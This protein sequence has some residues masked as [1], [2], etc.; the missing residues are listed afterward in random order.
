[1]TNPA[2]E[3]ATFAPMTFHRLPLALLAAAALTTPLRA[4]ATDPDADLRELLRDALYTEEVTRDPEAAAKQYEALLSK[5]DAQR[6]FAASALFRLAEVRRK[7][8]RKDEAIA[9][10]QRLLR[11]FPAAEAEA[12][13]AREN[14]AAMG[15]KPAEI[16]GPAEEREMS[17]VEW[18]LRN[19]QRDIEQLKELVESSPDVLV[20]KLQLAVRDENPL[21]VDF[22]LSKG[23]DPATPGLLASA[24][25]SG[26]L[27]ICKMLIEKGKPSKEEAGNALAEAVRTGRMAILSY[28]LDQGLDPDSHVSHGFGRRITLLGIAV[29]TGNSE[30]AKEFLDR[31][32]DIDTM[33]PA[34][35][36][37]GRRESAG[38]ALHF[39]VRQKNGLAMVR[40]LLER[41]AKPDVPT[42]VG[43][44]T[45]LHLAVFEDG[46]QSEMIV[47][48]LLAR[49]ADPNRSGTAELPKRMVAGPILVTP[50]EAALEL[51]AT[52]KI[53]S[54]LG[55]GADL[56]A[57]DRRGWPPLRSVIE[58]Q[59]PELVREFLKAGADPNGRDADGVPMLLAAVT[60][61][62][63]SE[64]VGRSPDEHLVARSQHREMVQVLLDASADPSAGHQQR[65]PVR[66]A[67]GQKNLWPIAELLL[68]RGAKPDEDWKK[69]LFDGAD[70]ATRVRLIRRF[71][72]PEMAA[73][74][75]ITCF[76]GGQ[77]AVGFKELLSRKGDESPPPLHRLL[78]DLLEKQMQPQN[79]MVHDTRGNN[80]NY[81]ER[82]NEI[83]I[84]RH[85]PD[86]KASELRVDLLSN[87]P[88]PDLQWG[89][90]LEF[91]I[92]RP[93]ANQPAP[94]PMW[95]F[96]KR[97]AF[98]VTVEIEGRTRRVELRGD[99]LM[100]DP[101]SDQ[102]PWVGAGRLMSLLW[103]PVGLAASTQATEIVIERKGWPV[104]RL[105]IG[106]T[107]TDNLA[108]E[109]EDIVR[110]VVEKAD[111]AGGK[112]A[113]KEWWIEP[114][115]RL[116]RVTL[117]TPG[118]PYTRH[119]GTTRAADVR[120]PAASLPTL[121]QALAET[122][123]PAEFGGVPRDPA[124]VPAWL[125]EH[126]ADFPLTILPHPDFSKIRLRRLTDAG[127]EEVRDIDLTATIADA[128]DATTAVEARQADLILQ[129]GDIIELP[130][131]PDQKG[132]PWQGLTPREAAF[133]SKALSCRVQLTDGGG[134][135]LRDVRYA[136]ASF[137]DTAF[138]WYP[139]GPE[140]NDPGTCFSLRASVAL[141]ISGDLLELA[142]DGIRDSS[143]NLPAVHVF[144]R[145]GDA[146][147]AAVAPRVRPPNQSTFP[148]R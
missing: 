16:A 33:F 50:F 19:Q 125:A 86:G 122:I 24:A 116:T 41:G 29:E 39:A 18:K 52:A 6:A 23:V 83:L 32:A 101:T 8:D 49:G 9:L 90:I 35:V 1:M 48:E 109:P 107:S 139:L 140:G 142:R 106:A 30:A 91:Q 58:S 46:S 42:P 146:V 128:T 78:L 129:P 57:S 21:V 99:R 55:K 141:G 37:T 92:A 145:D 61:A 126:A 11:E 123:R 28:L 93:D 80:R 56:K 137:I 118:I 2:P 13:L 147:R 132:K 115:Q 130:L 95:S 84:T 45:P 87:E 108:L 71:V 22:L 111:S 81:R 85:V 3:A 43:N 121:L 110:L 114:S 94:S 112:D 15:S 76:P 36:I 47:D 31:G 59:S 38:T 12:K 77:S 134:V 131:R 124:Q 34:A 69:S 7:Q 98:P 60:A 72:F 144:L 119:F 26:N 75:A 88:F 20:G 65:T 113:G 44:I 64:G 73:L 51:D 82:P 102:V 105:P 103:Q 54:M 127:K 120:A 89:D 53:R 143:L 66:E 74:P 100:F 104:I 25:A 62:V 63:K 5:H 10:Y 136:P 27:A 148:S 70:P 14:L 4:Q 133:F 97:V 40:L 17:T 67:V 68:E 117:T 79:N 138:G 135:G 96:R